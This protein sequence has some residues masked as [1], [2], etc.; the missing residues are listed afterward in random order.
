MGY[1]GLFWGW[2][3]Y[4]ECSLSSQVLSFLCGGTGR[5][6]LVKTVKEHTRKSLTSRTS[7]DGVKRKVLFSPSSLTPPLKFL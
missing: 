6:F 4:G 7:F 3:I 5:V 2:D 1:K